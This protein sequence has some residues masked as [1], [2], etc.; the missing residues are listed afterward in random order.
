MGLDLINACVW[1]FDGP[2]D[3][4]E[5][6]S[7]LTIPALNS[8]A[9]SLNFFF[10]TFPVEFFGSSSRNTTFLGT[11]KRGM[12]IRQYTNISSSVTFVTSP[13]TATNAHGVSPQRA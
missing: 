13:F 9:I 6:F 3:L 10:S 11:I 2:A 4:I 7:L 8:R 1:K 12:L 5:G